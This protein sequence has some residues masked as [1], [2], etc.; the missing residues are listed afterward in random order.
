LECVAGATFERFETSECLPRQVSDRLGAVPLEPGCVEF[1]VW[2][3]HASTVHVGG[4][5]LQAERDG[6]FSARLE[7]APGTDYGYSLDDG[8]PLADPCS[9]WQPTG[10]RGPSR[11][12]DTA[13]FEWTEKPV[14]VPLPDLIVYELHIGTFTAAGTFAAAIERLPEL[15]TLGV[16]AVEVMPVATFPGERGWGYDGVLC[17]APHRAYGGPGGLAR[18]VE[19]AHTSGLAVL[20]DVVYNHVGPG[21]ELLSRFGPYFTDRHETFWGD[22]IDYTRRAVRE[23][24]IQNAEQWV[25]DYRVDGLRLDAT[26]AIFD[27]GEPHLLRELA[28]R[29]HAARPGA[30][31]IA[32][33]S[34]GDRRPIN[35]WG[36]DA[37]WDDSFHHA[38]HVLL[39]GEHDGYYEGYGT[40]ADLA[41]AFEATP[42]SGSCSARPITIRSAIAPSVTGYRPLRAVSRRRAC[43]SLRRCR[44]FFRATSTAR[45]RRSGSSPTTT[46]PRSRPPHAPAAAA[47]SPDSSRS[48]TRI[49]LTRRGMRPSRSRRSARKAATASCKSS[50]RT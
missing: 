31:V 34:I 38:L 46:I 10:L 27:D 40:V 1:R 50:T 45:W 18:F 20:L 25:R 3:P 36:H 11:V 43:C 23:W 44:S 5:L 8:A 26:H 15:A 24:A 22:A 12:L 17:W 9:R 42:P 48:Q 49:C 4:H 7:L 19:A 21:A 2:A 28:E 33:T 37:Q 30:L 14:T 16:T 47:S 41:W 29:V 39:T 6:L 13:A 35:E 32:E